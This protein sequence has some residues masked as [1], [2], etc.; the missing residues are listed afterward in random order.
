MIFKELSDA[1]P[2]GSAD[3]PTSLSRAS[4]CLL[5]GRT[6][7]SSRERGSKIPRSGFKPSQT[8]H[9]RTHPSCSLQLKAKPNPKASLQS[10]PAN[11]T[12]DFPAAQQTYS[13]KKRIIGPV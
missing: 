12:K 7:V 3:T 5:L 8:V 10:L 4:L 11:Q 9:P 6:M 13:E 1:K 2:A